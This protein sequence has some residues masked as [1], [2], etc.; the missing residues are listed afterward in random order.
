ME[1]QGLI[2]VII[3]VYN[4]EQYLCEC[5]DSVLNQT[6]QNFEIILVDDGS[7]DGSPA[8][9]DDYAATN[10]RVRCIHKENGGASS[11]RNVGLDAAKGEY[12][13]F[14]DSDDWL[15]TKAFEKL[16]IPMEDRRIDF[17]FCE[18][19]TVDQ[20]TGGVSFQNY[21]YWRNYGV[22]KSREFFYEMVE[23]KEFHVAVWMILYRRDFLMREH[24]RFV[25]K[26]MYEDCIFAYQVYQQA[27]Y[28]AHIHEYLYHRRYRR[29]SVMTAK[30]T[31][32]N[33][34][35]AKRAYEEVLVSWKHFDASGKDCPYVA[36]I[37]HNVLNTYRVLNGSDKRKYSADFA[38]V[39]QSIFANDAFSD[40][41]LKASC[42]GR[43]A[44]LLYKAAEKVLHR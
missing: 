19:C 1:K 3:P 28:A 23:K 41:G 34:L 5:V 7:R 29:N 8:I 24:L 43:A 42:S 37:A 22:G 6:W 27:D 21:A 38:E 32:Y 44:W 26:I 36:R 13:F 25:E 40:G 11:A 31:A 18:A 16:L 15:D 33:F 35:S 30:K 39:K 17:S 10:S 12:V 4:V 2:S 9:C 14:L 20:D